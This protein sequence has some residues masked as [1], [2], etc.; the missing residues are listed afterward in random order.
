MP[1]VDVSDS[2]RSSRAT[3]QR[4]QHVLLLGPPGV[5]KTHLSIA[6]RRE[7]ILVRDVVQF[8]TATTLVWP[9]QGARRTAP[10]RSCWRYQAESADRRRVSP[11]LR[12]SR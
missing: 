8:T 10:G 9:R 4:Q 7:A 11:S 6:L 2:A 12:R 1:L 3:L 5:R